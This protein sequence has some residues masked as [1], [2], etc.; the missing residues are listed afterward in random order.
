MSTV[1]GRKPRE[2]EVAWPGAVPAWQ[3]NP[4]SP[5]PMDVGQLPLL[6]RFDLIYG[7]PIEKGRTCRTL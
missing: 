1:I 5:R 4:Y 7:D 3:A 6:L 2:V